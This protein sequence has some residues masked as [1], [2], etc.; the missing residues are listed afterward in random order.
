MAIFWLILMI[1]KMTQQT[2]YKEK[3]VFEFSY[4]ELIATP[5]PFLYSTVKVCSVF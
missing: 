3:L 5:S 2:I 1:K 4:G